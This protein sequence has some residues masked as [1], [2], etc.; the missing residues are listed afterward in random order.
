MLILFLVELII[1]SFGCPF[2][3]GIYHDTSLETDNQLKLA[4]WLRLPRWERSD[5]QKCVCCS[6]FTQV[7]EK[8]SEASTNHAGV[9]AITRLKNT[10]KERAVNTVVQWGRGWIERLS[11]T[12]GDLRVIKLWFKIFKCFAFTDSPWIPLQDDINAL[13]DG[14]K[15]KESPLAISNYIFL[16]TAAS[17]PVQRGFSAS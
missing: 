17:G 7:R 4:S 1:L 9:G 14:S 15:A 13:L 2:D 5:H 6:Q 3:T 16:P 11:C 12:W 10:K 8:A